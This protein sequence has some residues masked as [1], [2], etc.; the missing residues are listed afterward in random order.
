MHDWW[1][2]RRS[3]GPEASTDLAWVSEHVEAG[4]AEALLEAAPHARLCAVCLE[5]GLSEDQW[6]APELVHL[7][8]EQD[9]ARLLQAPDEHRISRFWSNPYAWTAGELNPERWI[10]NESFE[11]RE[12]RLAEALADAGSQDRARYVLN[13]VAK[14]LSAREWPRA[15]QTTDDF[16]V[17]VYPDE[18]S[19]DVLI[20]VEFAARPEALLLLGQR[21]LLNVGEG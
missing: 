2:P 19:R 16:V 10:R 4:V 1:Q 11:A 15:L 6:L 9:R 12:A 8:S 17:Y 18:P 5:Y 7:C 21:G 3:L 13:H 20:N 14:R